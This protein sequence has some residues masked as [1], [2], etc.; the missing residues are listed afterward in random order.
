MPDEIRDELL[1]IRCYVDDLFVL[2]LHIDE[3]SVYAPFT[4]ELGDSC[5][6]EDEGDTSFL[7]LTKI[8]RES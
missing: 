2:A 5:D 1:I 3:H 8:I 6:V 4:K 7:V